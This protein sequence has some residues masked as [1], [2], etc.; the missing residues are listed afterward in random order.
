MPLYVPSHFLNELS[1]IKNMNLPHIGN[2]EYKFTGFSFQVGKK[3]KKQT[4]TGRGKITDLNQ[5]EKKLNIS[6]N[7]RY[8][9]IGQSEITFLL[10]LSKM[11]T[12]H[13]TNFISLTF[14]YSP[15]LFCPSTCKID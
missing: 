2:K 5:V 4:C 6:F 3:K 11:K 13:Q 1:L 8:I 9:I 14:S 12:Q 15:A 10:L 7:T